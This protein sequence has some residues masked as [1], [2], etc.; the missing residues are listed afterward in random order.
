MMCVCEKDVRGLW[1]WEGWGVVEL[2]S[3]EMD[4]D[5]ASEGENAGR[6]SEGGMLFKDV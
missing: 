3:E 4:E 6:E 1:V 5:G 2:L